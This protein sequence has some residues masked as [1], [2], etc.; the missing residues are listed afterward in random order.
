MVEKERKFLV[1]K[2]DWNSKV[3]RED[4]EKTVEIEQYYISQSDP[5][6]RIRKRNG[7][8]SYRLTVKQ[9]G[10]AHCREENE[11]VINKHQYRELKKSAVS[12]LKKK[13]YY[14]KTETGSVSV[15]FFED[16]DL[17]L[18]E[19]E[20]TDEDVPSWAGEEVTGESSYYNSKIA[21]VQNVL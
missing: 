17:I 6:V 15:D 5:E 20:N 13:R 21:S 8:E 7:G 19:M 18:L 4:V 9:G 3:S 14:L 2:D 12:G 10:Y 16:R 11:T 1:S